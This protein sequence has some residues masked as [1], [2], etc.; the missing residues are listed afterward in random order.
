M[1]V[2]FDSRKRVSGVWDN[3]T[4]AFARTLSASRFKL[5]YISFYNTF[6]N[7]DSKKNSFKVGVTTLSLNP[8]V[9]TVSQLAFSLDALVKTV[10]ANHSVTL[11][12]QNYLNWNI[13]ADVLG[14]DS[15]AFL[16]GSQD[17][18][19]LLGAFVTLPNLTSPDQICIRSNHL[20]RTSPILELDQEHNE[21]YLLNVLVDA[22]SLSQNIHRPLYEEYYNILPVQGMRYFNFQFT[23]ASGEKLEGYPTEWILSITFY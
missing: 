9:Y 20:V 10:N 4:L 11:F 13:G 19:T 6:F 21:P 3:C 14:G 16:L 17:R 1:N 8:G 7:V 22:P 23:N 18:G 2:V 5:N 15:A 12:E